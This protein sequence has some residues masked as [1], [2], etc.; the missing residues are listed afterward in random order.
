MKSD[1][2]FK[3]RAEFYH[4][5]AKE[6]GVKFRNSDLDRLKRAI[7]GSSLNDLFTLHYATKVRL[8]YTG[9]LVFSNPVADIIM[10]SNSLLDRIA[11]DPGHWAYHIPIVLKL[12]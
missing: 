5:K 2:L 10:N 8:D 9:E 3:L 12:T 11:K 4:K 6:L 7:P 1:K